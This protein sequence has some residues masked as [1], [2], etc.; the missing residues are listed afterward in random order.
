MYWEWTTL[1]SSPSS[2]ANSLERR[3][4]LSSLPA[5]SSKE[6]VAA[7]VRHVVSSSL[8]IS[9]P[10]SP[11]TFESEQD[12]EWCLQVC[13]DRKIFWADFYI[14]MRW[15]LQ[16]ICYGLSL[17]F[18]EHEII[19]DCV[20]IYCEWL[21]CL[22]PVPKISVPKPVVDR[23]DFYARKMINQLYH[24]F[25]PRKGEGRYFLCT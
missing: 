8:G 22:S 19:K 20:S 1:V 10:P 5:D 23:P 18:A 6:V 4:V 2:G 12:V 14:R 25:L 15:E 3:S 9:Q 7:V 24:L 16:V 13:S 21:S 11:S 17:P